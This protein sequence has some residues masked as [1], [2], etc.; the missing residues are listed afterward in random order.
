M[1]NEMIGVRL[2]WRDAWESL[3]GVGGRVLVLQLSAA[4]VDRGGW[5]TGIP[6][7]CGAMAEFPGVAGVASS[8]G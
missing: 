7:R 6:G 5:W 8:A 3:I 1:T 4:W 2:P